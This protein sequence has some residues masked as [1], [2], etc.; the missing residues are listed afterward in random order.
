MLELRNRE[1]KRPDTREW[2]S[3]AVQKV[4]SKIRER[5][6]EAI[7]LQEMAAVAYMSRYH[8]N[9]TFR[10]VTGISPGRFLSALRVEAATQ[11]LLNT[12]NSVTDICLDVGYSS[13]GT[14]IRRFS[15]VLGM[16]PMKLRMLR[17]SAATSLLEQVGT[18][19]KSTVAGRDPAVGGL[20]HA[21]PSFSGLIFVGLFS[22][23]I[24][25][26]V[27]VACDV[28]LGSGTYL[29]TPVP[30]GRYHVFALG[31][32]WPDTIN[33]YFRY[34]SSLRGGG[35]VVS[36]TS[37]TAKCQEVRLRPAVPTDPPIL[38]NLPILLIR[39]SPHARSDTRS[40]HSRE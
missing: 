30:A 8:F 14:F 5:L 21:P 39:N 4:I 6:D 37:G 38:L 26:G 29:I 9:R 31:L 34:D 24:P 16:S 20:V 35:E 17:R 27:P 19:D 11:M 23:P 18:D 15:D 10:Q 22:S 28:S 33:D 12:D 32:P 36:V 25:E 7:S 3:R 1:P 40:T 13:L 2:H